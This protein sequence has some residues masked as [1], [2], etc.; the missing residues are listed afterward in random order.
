MA[1]SIIE[2]STTDLDIFILD[3]QK[4]VHIATGGGNIPEKLL[5]SDRYNGELRFTFRQLLRF[6]ESEIEINPNISEITRL[7]E[8]QLQAYLIDFI[9]FAK[10]GIYTYDKTDLGN[11]ESLKFHLVAKPKNPIPFL[12]GLFENGIYR[13][14]SEIPVDFKPFLLDKYV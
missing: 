4:V 9:Y 12:F 14:D 7:P 13:I 3:K 2:L 8:E 6:P 10:L 1:Y 5:E 11:F